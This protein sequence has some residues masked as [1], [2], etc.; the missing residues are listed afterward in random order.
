MAKPSFLCIGGQRC[1][2]TRLHR[3]LDAHP[4][5]FM[6]QKGLGDF[7]KEIHYFDRFVL[8]RDFDWYESHFCSDGI[9]GEITP[10]YSTL[11]PSIVKSIRE[12]LPE[13]KI[14]YVIR[15]PADRI[16]SQI[17]MMHSSWNSSALR[18]FNL[19]VLVRLFDSPAVHLRSDY[20]STF[21]L[22]RELFGTENILLLAFEELMVHE[23]LEKIFKFLHVESQWRPS[24]KI[25]SKVLSSQ[26]LDMPREL[27]WLCALDWLQ[28]LEKF[29]KSHYSVKWL[30]KM[31]IDMDSVPNYFMDQLRNSCCP[32]G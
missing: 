4:E 3:I 20:L 25:A 16:W 32:G 6:T 18:D 24:G 17:R 9:S 7:N 28:M 29:S 23:G 31:R 12:Y 27:R 14:I 10:A 22:W 21:T 8:Q 1:G 26:E 11:S 19:E 30:E 2:T 5:I 15:N 13:V